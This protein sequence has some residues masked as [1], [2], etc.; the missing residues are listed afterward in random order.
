MHCPTGYRFAG[1][2]LSFMIQGFTPVLPWAARAAAALDPYKFPTNACG[3]AGRIVDFKFCGRLGAC[4]RG[5][6]DQESDVERCGFSLISRQNRHCSSRD[7]RCAKNNAVRCR[8]NGERTA[9]S[10]AE[11]AA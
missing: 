4:L 6:L 7:A 2:W 10:T 3:I 1:T 9:H 11:T 8:F 5:F